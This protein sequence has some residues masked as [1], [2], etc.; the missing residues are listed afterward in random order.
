[1]S[2]LYEVVY[3]PK[4][5][6]AVESIEEKSSSLAEDEVVVAPTFV[7]VCG[8]DLYHLEVYN[9]PGL[10]L[11]H[12]W[13]GRVLALGSRVQ[14]LKVGDRVTSSAI[15]SCGECDSCKNNEA[16]YCLDSTVLGSEKVGAL[17]SSLRLKEH[18]LVLV[19]G[20]VEQQQALLEVMAVG[21][22][23][24]E[25][26]QSLTKTKTQLLVMG[27]GSVGLCT[28]FVARDQG[29]EVTMVESIPE[30]V[31]RARG[32][33]LNVLPLGVALLDTSLRHRFALI[34]D[35]TGDHLEGKG[36]WPY[37][38]YFGAKNF[39][40]VMVAKYI[41]PVTFDPN[42]L[43]LLQA[44]LVWMRGVS[45][46]CLVKTIKRWSND[47]EFNLLAQQL[48]THTVPLKNESDV[49]A[50]FEVARDR[51]KSGKVL[52]RINKEND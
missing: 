13:V 12:E 10:K 26:L 8:S 31:E 20:G 30:R 49:T 22:Q 4:V 23:A 45:K 47:P 50:A 38:T 39:K 16:Q 7:G 34:I 15:L 19:N 2:T 37:L 43:G 46:E 11:G 25:H 32:L 27:A 29:Y 35:A 18:Q 14:S 17:R 41:K 1:M 9:G 48:I 44:K 3:R 51:K 5:G 33:G 42:Q 52:I 28:G 21:E 36:A 40:G 24:L 6:F